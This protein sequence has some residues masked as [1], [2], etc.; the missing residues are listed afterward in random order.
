MIAQ[1]ALLPAALL[2]CTRV[3][4]LEDGPTS[5]PDS[6]ARV[7]VPAEAPAYRLP[8]TRWALAALYA[9]RR[10][11][12]RPDSAL[13]LGPSWF[14]AT[15]WQ[16]SGFSCASYGD[17]WSVD[18]LWASDPGCLGL[19]Q[20]TTWAELC[21]LWP[22]DYA[23]DGYAGSF[24]GDAP[25]ASSLAL[26]WF[27][28]AGHALLQRNGDPEAWYTDA[29]DPLAPERMTATMHYWGPWT[30]QVDDVYQ[31]CPDDIEA[32]L[33]GELERHVAG[34]ADKVAVLEEAPCAT[35]PLTEADVRAF[36]G[37]LR[38]A[39]P[40]RSWDAAADRAVERLTGAGL[41]VDA[42]AVLDALDEEV[43]LRLTCPEEELYTWYR[44]PCP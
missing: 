37:G 26:A 6:T 40:G 9:S 39:R 35:Q 38:D 36:V 34:V 20:H 29:G 7:C 12:D 19:E 31:T 8:S 16:M 3:L 21:K 5:P 14:L 30:G 11:G 4:S 10:L 13:Q 17:P 42:P 18:P 22:A 32:C 15:G 23:C 2:G 1:L 44:W 27:A 41:D 25:E 33:D 43:D 24:A 28:L